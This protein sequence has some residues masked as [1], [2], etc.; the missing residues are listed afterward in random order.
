MKLSKFTLSI[1]A[2]AMLLSY[3]GHSQAYTEGQSFDS[4]CTANVKNLSS[5][6]E[7]PLLRESTFTLALITENH[8]DLRVIYNRL[9]LKLGKTANRL[10]DDLYNHDLA[11]K[12]IA[13]EIYRR[14]PA[15]GV[16]LAA[17]CPRVY[18]TNLGE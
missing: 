3:S 15:F 13:R 17:A 14:N 8:E 5:Q 16:K 6:T 9:W 1:V 11:A 12:N 7:D 18:G 4:V 2:V 10:G